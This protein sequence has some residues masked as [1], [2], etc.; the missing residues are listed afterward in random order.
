V[1]SL[2]RLKDDGSNWHSWKDR[3]TA[4]LYS[5]PGLRKQ[6]CGEVKRP[7]APIEKAGRF[8]R[9]DTEV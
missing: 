2:P 1:S 8:Y 3:A 7:V 9:N 6:L 4:L 5:K